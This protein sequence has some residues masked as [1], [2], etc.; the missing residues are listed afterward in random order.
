MKITRTQ[1]ADVLLIEPR[2]FEDN[3]GLF[4]EAYHFQRYA[5][6]GV[7]A[8]FVQDNISC[9]T[10]GVLRGLHYQL[11][12]PQGKLIIAI[13]GKIFDVAID[14]RRGSPTFGKWVG[15]TLAAENYF[16]VYIPE[17][18]AH[19]FCVLSETATVLYKCTD[20]YAPAEER[21]IRWDDP[22]LAINWPVAEPILSQKDGAY[23][24]LDS[25]A[26]DQLPTFKARP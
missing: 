3:R 18:F 23:P 24:T 4:H 15:M 11:G 1:L 9:S 16:Q 26:A 14:I 5:E 8:S 21:G 19:G 10:R 2:I 6:H 17:G 12:R 13:Q 22:T 7:P 20:Y 25:L